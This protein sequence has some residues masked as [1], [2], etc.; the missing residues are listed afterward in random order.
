MIASHLVLWNFALSGPMLVFSSYNESSP[1]IT[2]ACP[3]PLKLFISHCFPN[4]VGLFRLICFSNHARYNIRRYQRP[5][6]YWTIIEAE[7]EDFDCWFGSSRCCPMCLWQCS[8]KNKT[9]FIL[10]LLNVKYN[11]VFLTNKD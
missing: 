4:F 6:Y 8:L 1:Q 5:H 2:H 3:L 11:N 9:W 10:F 7:A